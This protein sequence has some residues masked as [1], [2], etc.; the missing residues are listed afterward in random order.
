MEMRHLSLSLEEISTIKH[1]LVDGASYADRISLGFAF[2]LAQIQRH[3]GEE[4]VV[5]NEIEVLEGITGNS[6]TKH[7]SQFKHPPLHPFWHKHFS[8]RRHLLRNACEWWGLGKGG[9]K[10]LLAM[11]E[12]GAASYGDQPDLLQKWLAYQLMI[13]GLEERIAKK[14]IT[15]D[16]VIFAKHDEQNFYLD[17]A[18]HEEARQDPH[19]L[20][21]RLRLGSACEFPFLFQ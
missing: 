1:C 5:L 16:W 4:R 17:F 20:L 19:R 14:R 7:A 18:T 12:D 8:T 2:Q 10:R 11:I 9:N 21:E 15:G 13:G 3:F 6:M